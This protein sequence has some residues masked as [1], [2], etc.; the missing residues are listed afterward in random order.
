MKKQ[1]SKLAVILTTA[2][3]AGNTMM[4]YAGP[5]DDI[6]LKSGQTAQTQQ[7]QA[8]QP[9]EVPQVQAEAVQTQTQAQDDVQ[10]GG[11]GT[12]TA[13]QI[14]ESQSVPEESAVQNTAV[15]VAVNYVYDNYG[16]VTALSMNLNNFEG[17]GGISYRA[18][19]TA[20]GYLWWFRN[21][22]LTGV[23]SDGNYVQAV[24]L[25]LTGEAEKQYDVY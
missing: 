4:A 24:Q 12:A 17:I 19:N 13:Q 5:A 6:A 22:T 9:S 2:M 21:G 20:G 7:T 15:H 10:Y 3:V 14:N 18:Y 16:N 11:P 8:A 23:P 1:Y 25:Q